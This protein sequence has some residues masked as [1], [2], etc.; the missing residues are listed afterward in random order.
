MW[1]QRRINVDV[2]TTTLYK[3]LVPRFYNVAFKL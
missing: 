2:D 3:R 1:L